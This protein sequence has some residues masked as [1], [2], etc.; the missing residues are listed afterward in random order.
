MIKINKK[1]CKLKLVLVV[2]YIIII[3]FISEY[4]F[5]VSEAEGDIPA[6]DILF[7]LLHICEFG[8]LSV[9]LMFVFYD[10]LNIHIILFISI[11]YGIF[12]EIHQYFVPYRVFDFKDI[13][14]NSI[15]SVLGII[16]FFVLL[17][18]YN[19]FFVFPKMR[20]GN[21]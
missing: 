4:K 9:L 21:N 10:K 11:L 16:G 20:W 5:P 8:L 17:L 13:I 14:Y 2:S 1:I 7:P 3:Y 6:F 15:G 19:Y 18:M 12:D